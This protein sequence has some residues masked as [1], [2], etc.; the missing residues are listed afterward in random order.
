MLSEALVKTEKLADTERGE[1]KG[2]GKARGVDRK[3]QDSARDGIAGGGERQH[4][5]EN[6]SDAGRPTERERETEQEAAPDAGLCAAGLQANIAIEPTRHRR[7]EETDHGKREKVHGAESGEKR[8][9]AEKRDGSENGEQDSE[10]EAGAHGE[11]YQYAEQVQTEEENESAGNGSK[12]SAVLAEKRAD[13]AGGS[14]KGNEHDRKS[15]HE[16]KRGS[17]QTAAR[18]LPLA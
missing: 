2:N 15:K 3:K 14:A 4:G 7:P 8:P 6:W 5:R 12:Q 13:G 9:A 16:G 17:E 18:R 10:N 1:K 11:F